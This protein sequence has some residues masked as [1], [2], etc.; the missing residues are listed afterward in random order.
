[1]FSRWGASVDSA[2]FYATPTQIEGMG[3]PIQTENNF[4]ELS[5]YWL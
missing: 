4:Q 1:M 5:E 3:Y 2:I